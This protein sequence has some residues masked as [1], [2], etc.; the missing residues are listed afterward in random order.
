MINN[1]FK[2]FLSKTNTNIIEEDIDTIFKT[3][4]NFNN[5]LINNIIKNLLTLNDDYGDVS[6]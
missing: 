2:I 4:M 3:N 1:K 5:E 6:E